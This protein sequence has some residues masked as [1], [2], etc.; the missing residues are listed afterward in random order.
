MNININTEDLEFI[1]KLIEREAYNNQLSIEYC[2]KKYPD[3]VNTFIRKYEYCN[4][5][6][7][8]IKET[9]AG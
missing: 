2:E 9:A 8:R 1:I 3:M 4:E 5:L 7:S 6:N